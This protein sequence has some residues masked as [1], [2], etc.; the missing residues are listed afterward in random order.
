MAQIVAERNRTYVAASL[1][2]EFTTSP[3]CNANT[4]QWTYDVYA[5]AKSTAGAL[6]RHDGDS[7]FSITADYS[8]GKQL[9]QFATGFAI[10][11][12]GQR[13]SAA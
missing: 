7:W 2:V 3:A 9:Q 10:G 11:Q 8:F 12:R 1:G 6:S 13:S 5:M 4:I